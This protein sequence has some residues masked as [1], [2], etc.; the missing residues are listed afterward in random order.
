MTISHLG[1]YLLAAIGLLGCTSAFAQAA[2]YPSRPVKIMVP[3]AAAAGADH[4][5]RAVANYLSEKFKQPFTVVNQPGGNGFI[6]ARAVA[7]APPDGYTLLIG[8]NSP[9]ATNAAMFKSMPYDPVKDFA[10]IAPLARF[11]LIMVV[12]ANSP[13]NSIADLVAAARKEPGKLN[14]ASSTAT[15]QLVLELFNDK[16]KIKAV[17]VHYK[18]TPAAVVDLASGIVQ[19]SIFDASA[20]LPLIRAGKL[21]PLAVTGVKRSADLPDVPTMAESG[22]E[23]Y[24][25]Y[26]WIAAFSPANVDPAIIAKLSEAIQEFVKSPE[27]A[28]FLADKKGEPFVGGPEILRKFQAD[29]VAEMK[30][31]VKAA[32]IEQQ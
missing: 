6:A 2:D 19:Y 20:V 5:A 16:N 12:S 1:S 8:A 14:F 3:H 18:A 17:S 4:V 13:Y 11:P 22:V 23:G 10:P 31:I 9:M 29:E 27:M 24:V 25:A 15:I 28:A 30:R 21:R 32:N 26:A 7:S